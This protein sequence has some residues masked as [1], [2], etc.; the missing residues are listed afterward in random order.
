[1]KANINHKN[2]GRSMK[3]N[4]WKAVIS[5]AFLLVLSLVV[6]R[7]QQLAYA[8]PLEDCDL[9][10]YD[11]ATGV[12]VPW[13]GYDETKGDTPAGPGTG[14]VS[15]A[16]P[17]P[18][19]SKAPTAAPTATPVPT[20]AVTV[21]PTKAP[22][23]EADGSESSN[24]SSNGTSSNASSDKTSNDISGNSNN[25]NSS[26]ANSSN[27]ATAGSVA[28]ATGS[29]T[30][31][32]SIASSG[33]ND[34][35]ESGSKQANIRNTETTNTNTTSVNTTDTN[36]AGTGKSNT[37]EADANITDTKTTDID[38]ANKDTVNISDQ[39]QTATQPLAGELETILNTKGVLEVKDTSG[40]LIHAG[41][42]L[43]IT[44][45]GFAGNTN[46]LELELHSEAL[47]LGTVS[48]IENGSFELQANIPETLEAGTHHI[49]V[50]Y[51]GNEISRQPIQVGP[52]AADS[53]L[54][55][56][57]VG[58]TKEN[59]GFL[60]GI[61]VLAGLMLLGLVALAGSILIKPRG[62]K[63]K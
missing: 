22:A 53:F 35:G 37:V 48:T 6:P 26:K 42:S 61:T 24:K 60:P 55:A 44:G 29:D 19:P 5:F 58:F 51:Q 36:T 49:V 16:S 21:A 57:S 41:S 63:S 14:K 28:G 59:K 11:D 13:P 56:I 27:I 1:M 4:A 15:T 39:E 33:E 7:G 52:R 12:P 17:T 9:D 38:A 54:E 45:S 62:I 46:D 40:S 47:S 50:L 34:K 10:G 31:T 20:A 2:R 32:G 18:A 25:N 30:S 23:K 8:A 43:I 3:Y